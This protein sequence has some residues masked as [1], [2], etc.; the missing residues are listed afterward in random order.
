MS[1]QTT[2]TAGIDAL[3]REAL[4][5]GET[6]PG[7]SVLVVQNGETLFRQSYGLAD[8]GAQIPN[9]P[10]TNFRLASVSKQFTAMAILMLAEQG[11]LTLDS[12][13]TSFF[14]R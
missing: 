12:C 10:A 2:K 4:G 13:L 8:I 5:P 9:T 6:G 14:P 7:A 11:N 1:A 3:L